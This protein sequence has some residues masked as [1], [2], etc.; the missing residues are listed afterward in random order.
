MTITFEDVPDEEKAKVRQQL[1]EYC[2]MDTE[3]MV[4][5]MEQLEEIAI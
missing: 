3:G 4:R 2:K 5:I 1:L